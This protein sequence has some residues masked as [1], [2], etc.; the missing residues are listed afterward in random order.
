M[1]KLST[2]KIPKKKRIFMENVLCSYIVLYIEAAVLLLDR[3][4]KLHDTNSFLRSD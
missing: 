4:N 2:A 3:N 1:S